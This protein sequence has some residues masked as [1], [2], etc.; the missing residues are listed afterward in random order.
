MKFLLPVACC[1]LPLASMSAQGVEL[2]GRVRDPDARPVAGVE[3]RAGESRALTDSLGRFVLRGLSGDSVRLE[4]RAIGYRPLTRT[5]SLQPP[6]EL[7][8]LLVMQPDRT[9]LPEIRATAR[10]AKPTKYLGTTKY[11]GFFQRQKLGL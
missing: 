9:V 11:D 8:D 1:L 6:V 7:L 5:V 4:L 3:V 2:R 10:P